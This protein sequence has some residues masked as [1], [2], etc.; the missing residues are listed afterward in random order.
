MINALHK[1]GQA[2]N[3]PSLI[4]HLNQDK[5][6]IHYGQT[7]SLNPTAMVG[8]KRMLTVK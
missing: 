1:T 2:F 5:M 7:F 6:P 8:N 4:K 3:L